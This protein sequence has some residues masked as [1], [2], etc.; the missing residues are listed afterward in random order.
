M[1][2]TPADTREIALLLNRSL[3]GQFVAQATSQEVFIHRRMPPGER[4][5]MRIAVLR[6][7]RWRVRESGWISGDS[8]SGIGWRQRA[9]AGAAE[10]LKM[11]G[12][13]EYLDRPTT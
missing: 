5:P 7:R 10:A 6:A 1:K 3:P 2:T 9:A 8:Y 4:K 12:Y 11:N 13:A